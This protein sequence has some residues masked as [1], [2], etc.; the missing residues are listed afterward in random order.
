MVEESRLYQLHLTQEERD[1]LFNK[2]DFTKKLTLTANGVCGG[3]I[4]AIIMQ[5]LR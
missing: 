5:I 1:D 2:V 4:I 3:L